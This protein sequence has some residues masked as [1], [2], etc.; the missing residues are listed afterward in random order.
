[1]S[2]V[3]SFL[4]QFRIG[5]K[6]SGGFFAVAM[7]LLVTV[8]VT[9][10][11][12]ERAFSVTS[13]IIDL[14]APTAQNS[15]AMLN[16]INHSLAALR[17]WI[18]IGKDKFKDERNAAWSDE[19]EPSLQRME[20][21][22]KNWT[23]PQNIERLD[24][25]KASLVAFKQYQLEIEDIAHSI[26]NQ[27]ALKILL[28]EAAPQ[29]AILSKKITEMI[30]LET[31]ESA[32]RERKKLLG[33]LADVRGTTGL[34]LANIRAYLLSGD[35]KFADKFYKN[36]E[37]NDVRY[38]D[39]LNNRAL[40]TD[41]QKAALLAFSQAREIFAP[42]PKIMFEKR[43][44][45]EWNMANLWL[46]TKAAPAAFAIKKELSAMADNQVEL[47]EADMVLAENLTANLNKM[48]WVLL[49]VGLAVA[50]A[51]GVVITRIITRPLADCVAA[52]NAISEGDLSV[53]VEV[54][55]KDEIGDLL[56]AMQTMVVQVS[57]IVTTVT[58]S[59]DSVTVGSL[60]LSSTSQQL[61]QNTSEQAASLEE[62]SASM[63]EMAANIRQSADNAQQTEKIAQQVAKDAE[64]G[65]KAVNEAVNAMKEIANTI[66][67][68]EEIARQT[69]LL[70][71]NAAIEAARAGEHG[72]GFAVVASEV[73]Q[74]AQES[75]TAAGEIGKLSSTSMEVAERA[76]VLLGSIVPDIRKTAGLVQE[77]SV[78]V[79]EQDTGAGQINMAI[80][81]LDKVVQQGAAAS[82]E[83]AST[84][85]E[86]LSRAEITQSA[87]SF[88]TINDDDDK[89]EGS[90][91]RKSKKSKRIKSK[92]KLMPARK[93]K[94]ELRTTRMEGVDIDLNDDEDE[95]DDAEFTRYS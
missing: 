50:G 6:I 75:K 21:F 58:E 56:S 71:L 46:G 7:V 23:N 61:S 38:D 4:S 77:I 3:I 85:E 88:F 2:K 83:V 57:G 26:D 52:M 14:R 92:T 42:L 67:V 12:V 11:E 84:A 54:K 35:K 63:E 31:K 33:I 59:S 16:G 25:V 5:T 10:A 73:R 93:A 19:I 20:E 60:Q 79:Q 51:V 41:S 91:A 86:L 87:I 89:A 94:D 76:G 22:S 49:V 30:D 37:K 15:L 24:R 9:R 78:A 18:I 17:G 55:S 29:A 95:D 13:R 53:K 48:L 47:M 40:L 74:L 65:G 45:N 69:N 90:R 8:L 44:S 62:V 32:T 36:W 39:L 27:P 80:Q 68:I 1:M 72:K 81:Q 64:E 43:S 34:G 28:M 70:A 66:S 82:E